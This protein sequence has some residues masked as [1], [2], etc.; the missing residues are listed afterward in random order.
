MSGDRQPT[1]PMQGHPSMPSG[2]PQPRHVRAA[3]LRRPGRAPLHEA[4]SPQQA[5]A[6]HGS[7]AAAAAAAAAAPWLPPPKHG[8]GTSNTCISSTSLPP[9]VEDELRGELAL[10][11][12]GLQWLSPRA[13]PRATQLRVK[14]WGEPG[15]G[16]AAPLQGPSSSDGGSAVVQPDSRSSSVGGGTGSS[17]A[18]VVFPV[19]VGPKLLT[20]YLRD[21]GALELAFEEL[22]NGRPV[23]TAT[24]GLGTARAAAPLAAALPLLGPRGQA[25]GQVDVQLHASF[26]GSMASFEMNEH[27]ASTERSLPLYPPTAGAAKPAPAGAPAGAMVARPQQL[28][29]WGQ[30]GGA[31]AEAKENAGGQL[32]SDLAIDGIN[33]LSEPESAHA[34]GAE[35]LADAAAGRADPLSDIIEKAERL[36]AAMEAAMAKG[37]GPALGLIPQQ[38]A[39]SPPLQERGGSALAEGPAAPTSTAGVLQSPERH[40][41]SRL[42][43]VAA[44]LRLGDG[45]VDPAR[46]HGSLP[47]LA[48]APSPGSSASDGDGSGGGR[49]YSDGDSSGC[50]GLDDLEEIEDLLLQQLFF[51]AK[52]GNDKGRARQQCQQD[53]GGGEDADA[54]STAPPPA[55]GSASVAAATAHS[56]AAGSCQSSA[57]PAGPQLVVTLLGVRSVRCGDGQPAARLAARA[58]VAGQAAATEAAL[59]W[60]QD[61]SNDGNSG[62]SGGGDSAGQLVELELEAPHVLLSGPRLATERPV[63]A[64]ELWGA[65][66]GNGTDSSPKKRLLLGIA[67]VPLDAAGNGYAAVGPAG[68]AVSGGP[69]QL[70]APRLLASGSF[71]VWDVLCGRENGQLQLAVTLLTLPAAAPIAVPPSP[72]A[73]PR[74]SPAKSPHASAAS[75]DQQQAGPGAAATSL[76]PAAAEAAVSSAPSVPPV[77]G[78]LHRF[79]VAV[80]SLS[81]LPGP[82]ALRAAG[83]VAPELR[84]AGYLFPGEIGLGWRPGSPTAWLIVLYECTSHVPPK[85]GSP[86]T[87]TAPCVCL[88]PFPLVTG[89]S[90]ALYTGLV[91]CEDSTSGSGNAAGALTVFNASARHTILLPPGAAVAAQLA[92]SGGEADGGTVPATKLVFQVGGWGQ[93]GP[94]GGKAAVVPQHSS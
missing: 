82:A 31:G 92:G 85:Q 22:P 40:T 11:V 88:F 8:G 23:A 75:K 45:P 67:R 44:G 53:G 91:P 10:T 89:D 49:A 39:S 7:A 20:R 42:L 19:R 57:A 25:L 41:L 71:P 48:A 32:A 62:S 60:Q 55:G 54:A 84:F 59:P 52:K 15:A 47:S 76:E 69:L 6:A 5:S 79:D 94:G 1:A 13:A 87:L 35:A 28:S 72:G 9:L 56:A 77:V 64:V 74:L 24:L 27:L 16:T 12:S 17:C 90:E 36:K 58:R 63:L 83:Q 18:R 73:P 93:G 26:S 29:L 81:G 80:H 3:S 61:S 51:P 33:R 50:S 37:L 68:T 65:G 34:D 43:Q 38:S 21:A 4:H 14:W 46:A 70:D 30:G 2:P 86:Q 66:C 78:V